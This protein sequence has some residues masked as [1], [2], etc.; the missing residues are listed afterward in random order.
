MKDVYGFICDLVKDV[1][2]KRLARKLKTT[3]IAWQDREKVRRYG[4]AFVES[5]V[6]GIAAKKRQKGGEK[7]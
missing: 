1:E 2:N 3:M 5:V 4:K 7:L 6:A